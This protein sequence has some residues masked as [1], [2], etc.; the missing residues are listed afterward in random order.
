MKTLSQLFNE[1]VAFDMEVWKLKETPF[2]PKQ[3]GQYAQI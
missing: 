2:S 1:I 3:A